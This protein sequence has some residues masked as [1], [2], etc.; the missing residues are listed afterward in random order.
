MLK[1]TPII[2]MEDKGVF[3]N[4]YDAFKLLWDELTVIVERGTS[5]QFLETAC[6]L[7]I[8]SDNYK[9][10]LSFY[11]ARDLAYDCGLIVPDESAPKSGPP[12][13]VP[14][15]TDPEGQQEYLRQLCDG[16]SELGCRLAS[17]YYRYMLGELKELGTNTQITTNAIVESAK[18][19]EIETEVI[20]SA[21]DI[22]EQTTAAVNTGLDDSEITKLA[23]SQA[24]QDIGEEIKAGPKQFTTVL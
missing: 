22:L 21:R 6:F 8:S 23:I 24:Y 14:P 13:L 15:P 18:G 7:E 20:E 3:D 4:F 17:T 5:L 12:P 11:D 1:F 9:I 16:L 2:G 10:P 19:T